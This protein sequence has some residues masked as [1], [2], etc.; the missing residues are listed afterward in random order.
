MK[1]ILVHLDASPRAATRL[2]LARDL[3]QTH[4]AA[5]KAI[6]AVLPALLLMPW[7]T[8]EGM[9]AAAAALAEVDRTQRE[10]A[11]ALFDRTAGPAATWAETGAEG[12]HDTLLA[13]ALCSDL[14][15][16]GQG[17]EPNEQTGALPADFVPALITD[18]GKPTLVVPYVGEIAPPGRRVLLAWKPTREA[19]RAAAGALPWLRG[20]A[21][22]HIAAPNAQADDPGLALLRRW[23]ALHGVA[24]SVT[25]HALGDADV[26]ERLLSLAADTGADL[27]AMGCYGH[28]RA[29]EFV[30]GGATRSVLRA[31]T[32]PVLMAH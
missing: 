16:L 10:R 26:G 28:S 24:G 7:A 31:M 21:E 22:V 13:E 9:A 32:L 8:E 2:A 12:L 17:D 23:L 30:L 29:R 4:G 19:A 1:S 5:L 20:A 27:L 6:Y 14:L 11:R 15:V 25:A 18:S 3:A